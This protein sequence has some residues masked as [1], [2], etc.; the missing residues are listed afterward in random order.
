MHDAAQGIHIVVHTMTARMPWHPSQHY[1]WG[2]PEEDFSCVVSNE[3]VSHGNM[4]IG[5]CITASQ[6]EPAKH[7]M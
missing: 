6:D 1:L 4:A 7:V 2:S 3:I 5:C